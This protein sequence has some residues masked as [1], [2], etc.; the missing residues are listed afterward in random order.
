M[1]GLHPQQHVHAY[2]K[3]LFDAQRHQARKD[4]DRINVERYQPQPSV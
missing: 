3:S 4:E 1:P 2:G